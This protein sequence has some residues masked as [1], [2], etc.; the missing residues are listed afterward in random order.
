MSDHIKLYG[1]GR[2]QRG[3]ATQSAAQFPGD[4]PAGQFVDRSYSYAVG[5]NWQISVNK[6]NN[7]SYGSVV[8]DWNF[9][10]PSNAL[11]L[12]QISFATGTTTLL[13][14]PYANP[15]N[16]QGRHIPIPQ[17]ADT[18][19]WQLG[20]HSL[21]FG[22]MFKWIHTNEYTTLDYN[23]LGIGLGGEIQ[24]LTAS[25][26]PSN[27][28]KPSSTAQVTYDSAFAAAL[29]RV[30]SLSS[31]FNYDASGNPLP[32]GSNSSREYKYYQT[33]A[34]LSDTWK[35]NPSLTL[36]Y[37][38]NYQIF[39]VPYEVHGLE[40]VQSTGFDSYFAARLAQ[41]AAGLT[42]ANAVPF[43]TYVLGG[44]ANNGPD[45][46]HPD[47]RDLAPRFAFAFNPSWDRKTVFNAGGSVVYDRTVVSASNTS[48]TSTPIS[49][50]SRIP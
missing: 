28:F 2:V 48:R 50:S 29:G 34:Y 17:V 9:P 35:V 44:P 38:L 43:I 24:G 10:R 31:T 5:M 42:G 23:S 22:G 47:Y 46:Y 15:T 8:Q 32:Q 40:T 16:A 7:L 33:L 39:S 49:S 26:R 4:Q 14:T 41:S 1:I 21:S 27:L 11:G 25:L 3:N 36:T 20:R 12:N 37:G 45:L 18:F 19:A 30:G 13:D 6:I